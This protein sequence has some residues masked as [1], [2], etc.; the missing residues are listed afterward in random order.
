MGHGR[1]WCS[2]AGV[3]RAFESHNAFRNSGHCIIDHRWAMSRFICRRQHTG[4][5]RKQSILVFSV[6]KARK[7]KIM[8]NTLRHECRNTGTV[9]M[10]SNILWNCVSW[11]LEVRFFNKWC[12][13]GFALNSAQKR[14]PRECTEFGYKWVSGSDKREMQFILPKYTQNKSVWG[15]FFKF[16]SNCVYGVRIVVS[17][18]QF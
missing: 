3:V 2:R 9:P 11:G 1:P 18:F 4:N 5:Q 12:T 7:A 14:T 8:E 6:R 16:D 10:K 17:D 13:A 15:I